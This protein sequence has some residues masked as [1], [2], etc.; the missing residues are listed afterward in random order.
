VCRGI[1]DI[2]RGIDDKF[3]QKIEKYVNWW[4]LIDTILLDIFP[5]ILQ[6]SAMVFG[7]IRN[8]KI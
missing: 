8:K 3:N 5:M 7:Y 2:L 6:L 1:I 4:N